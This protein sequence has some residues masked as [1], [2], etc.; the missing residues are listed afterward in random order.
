MLCIKFQINDKLSK[1]HHKPKTSTAKYSVGN[2]SFNKV[3]NEFVT[4]S[5]VGVFVLFYV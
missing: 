1:A 3:P 2:Y 5:R 4:E